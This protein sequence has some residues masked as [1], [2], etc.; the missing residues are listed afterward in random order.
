MFNEQLKNT[1]TM[2]SSSH[3]IALAITIFIIALIIINQSKIRNSKYLNK[4]AIALATFT[5]LQELSVNLWRIAFNEWALSTS[6]PLHLCGLGVLSSSYILVKKDETL[7]HHI[8]FVML[9]GAFL[10]L[11]TPSIDGSYGFPHFRFIQ[12]FVAHAMIVINFTFILF[13]YDFQRNFR[14]KHL[15]TN[16]ISL[17]IIAAIIFPIN[18]L[19]D[20]NYL[21]LMAKPGEGT[22]F[23]LFGEWPFYLINILIFGI[24]VFFHIFY[25]PFFIKA[26]Y[27]KRK[28]QVQLNKD[29]EEVLI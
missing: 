5:I 26:I 3:L 8:F 7:F 14:Y 6:L 21:F 2:Y 18:L 15:L 19:L 17:I 9:I 4:I 11:V 24:P 10:A 1:F 13:I 20:G 23:D 12:F 29:Q 27:L 16:A 22:A 25:L 28:N